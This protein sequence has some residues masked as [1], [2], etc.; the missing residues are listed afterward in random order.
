MSVL[1]DCVDFAHVIVLFSDW[2]A[3]VFVLEPS[4]HI[5][6]AGHICVL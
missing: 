4:Y 6:L 3:Q 2:P 5:L 1:S